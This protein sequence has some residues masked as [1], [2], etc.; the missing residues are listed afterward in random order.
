[1]T[2]LSILIP[3]K[4]RSE[5]LDDILSSILKWERKDFEIIIQDNSDS[6]KTRN[7]VEKYLTDNRV[8]YYFSSEEL[9]VI[10]NFEYAVNNSSGNIITAVGDDDGLLPAVMDISDWMLENAADAVLTDKADYVWPD[11]ISKYNSGYNNSK[12][13]LKKKICVEYKKIDPIEEL[14]KVCNHGGTTMGL[15]PRIYYGLVK[16]DCLCKVQSLTGQFFPGPSPDMA[17]AI[18]L[19]LIVNNFYYLQ[20]PAFIAGSSSKSTAGMGLKR[21]HVG[22]ISEIKHLPKNTLSEWDELIPAFWSGP[23]IWAQSASCTIKK[24]NPSYALNYNYLYA[25]CY[26]F[27]PEKYKCIFDALK[28]GR[29]GFKSMITVLFW[30]IY[31]WK[32]RLDNLLPKIWR[33]FG[34]IDSTVIVVDEQPNISQAVK[35][36]ITHTKNYDLNKY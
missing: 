33:K 12:L 20:Y 27:F 14:R 23:T 22:S 11:L 24:I 36:L 18:S 19:S 31:N 9:S 25:R 17:N 2:T 8:K 10:D 16:K 1:M 13:R 7:V 29:G 6:N 21:K 35:S 5:Y 4:N 26:V 30:Y 15:L 3:T 28:K 32:L 34:K